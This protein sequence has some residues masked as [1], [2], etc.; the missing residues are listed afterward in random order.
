MRKRLAMRALAGDAEPQ[1]HG[2]HGAV[3]RIGR[4]ASAALHMAS[5]AGKTVIQ[6][7]EAHGV[8]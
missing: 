1:H 2:R 5:D 3:V 6:R 8:A 7:A 4:G